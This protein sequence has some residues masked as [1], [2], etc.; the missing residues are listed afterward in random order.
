MGR[1]KERLSG[2]WRRTVKE[3]RNE[4]D[5]MCLMLTM[6]R[7]AMEQRWTEDNRPALLS[8]VSSEAQVGEPLVL[9]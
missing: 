4:R 3:V 1:G 6:A 7:T 8:R 2:S 5:G 9:G